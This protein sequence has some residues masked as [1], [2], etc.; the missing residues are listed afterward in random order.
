MIRNFVGISLR[1]FKKALEICCEFEEFKEITN[2]LNNV[3]YDDQLFKLQ[4]KFQNLL[5]KQYFEEKNIKKIYPRWFF[6]KE[7]INF[8]KSKDYVLSISNEELEAVI[9]DDEVEYREEA[10]RKFKM[11]YGAK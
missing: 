9:C 8:A 7:L 6:S 5:Y 10:E 11:L 4:I 1:L 3:R 2:E